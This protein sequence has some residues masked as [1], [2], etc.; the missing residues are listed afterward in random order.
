MLSVGV[1]V[2]LVALLGSWVAWSELSE[3][4]WASFEVA[5]EWFGDALEWFEGVPVLL[6]EEE[7][8]WA[9]SE[10]VSALFAA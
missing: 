3:L 4:L 1:L 7:A 5:L 6:E 9:S 2:L 10:D 8:L